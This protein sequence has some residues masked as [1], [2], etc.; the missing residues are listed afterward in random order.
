VRR[1]YRASGLVLWRDPDVTNRSTRTI[2]RNGRTGPSPAE[3]PYLSWLSLL[4]RRLIVE[5]A[6]CRSRA[7]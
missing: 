7:D 6:T 4:P 1:P 2:E 5:C 3:R